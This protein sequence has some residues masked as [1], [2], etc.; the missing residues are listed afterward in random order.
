M[1]ED[2]EK[3]E[4]FI[5]LW[6]KKMAT[7]NK[8]PSVI[9][10]TINKLELLQKENE[11]L[12]KKIAENIELISKSEDIIKRTVEEK[13]RLKLE[14]EEVTTQVTIKLN[15][16]EQENLELSNKVKSMVK[17]LLEKDEEIK[18]K[19]NE[20]VLLKQDISKPQFQSQSPADSVNINLVEELQSELSKKKSQII[21]LQASIS[22]LKQENKAL[23]NQQVEKLKSL[24]IDY[25]VPVE[26][27]EPAVIKPLPPET[28][29]KPLE[30]L[31]QDLQTDLNK[32]KKIIEKL[33]EEKSQ[34]RQALEDKGF[35]FNTED[36]EEL[37]RENVNLKRELSNLQND[38]KEK[39]K[40]KE[41][42]QE[43]ISKLRELE[44]KLA[45]K[46]DIIAQLKLSQP[47]EKIGT[48]GPMTGLIENLQ[49]TINKLKLTIQEKDQK[50]LEL[51][52]SIK[53][54]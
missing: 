24:P 8:S 21:D 9:E 30:L 54:A 44:G 2:N 53:G 15:E 50:I 26:N 39:S 3:I 49:S 4:D 11:Q 1:P 40:E 10:D 13:E 51:N 28:S 18:G 48:S 20:L 31:C 38:L 29:S 41:I 33:N 43:I 14:K 37:Q 27:I 42:P 22:E 6:K 32:Y 34:L 5:S 52:K 23:L 19:E 47:T 12:R 45:E 25:V 7:D 16:I 36:L 17:L 46:D 35:K